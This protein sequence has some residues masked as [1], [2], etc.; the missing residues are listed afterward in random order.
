MNPA[1]TEPVIFITGKIA[2]S[3]DSLS[4]NVASTEPVIFITGKR[5]PRGCRSTSGCS[6]NGA[7]D[8]HHRKVAPGV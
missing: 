8:L 2:R 6:F 5:T 4:A 7:G 3:A 1:S